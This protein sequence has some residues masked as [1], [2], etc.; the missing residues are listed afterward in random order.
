[1]KLLET[2]PVALGVGS[3]AALVDALIIVATAADWLALTN[4]QATAIVVFVTGLSVLVGALVRSTVW[5]PASV[6]HITT[7]GIS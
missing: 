2:E 7:P 4:E 3:I 6:A 1:M 5:S